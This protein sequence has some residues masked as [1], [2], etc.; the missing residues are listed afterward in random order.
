MPREKRI[1]K[2]SGKSGKRPGWSQERGRRA[3]AVRGERDRGKHGGRA[4]RQ[5]LWGGDPEP[6][7]DL[8]AIGLIDGTMSP[9]NVPLSTLEGEQN[10]P[11]PQGRMRPLH[12]LWR[13]CCACRGP[14]RTMI[15]ATVLGCAEGCACM[16]MRSF[17]IA[18]RSSTEATSYP[19]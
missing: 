8:R 19:V 11:S 1:R 16:Q 7:A 5:L 13:L 2:K 6:H 15:K 12:M 18:S 3:E 9:P 10:L 14:G 17:E 4:R